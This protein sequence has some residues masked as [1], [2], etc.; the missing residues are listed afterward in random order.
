MSWLRHKTRINNMRFDAA[1]NIIYIS[2]LFADTLLNEPRKWLHPA[3]QH[4]I[5]LLTSG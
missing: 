3:F 2:V 4:L 5:S 1:T